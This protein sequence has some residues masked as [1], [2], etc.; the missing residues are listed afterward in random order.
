[1]DRAGAFFLKQA[2]ADGGV[3][4]DFGNG[5]RAH[6]AIPKMRPDLISPG[7]GKKPLLES[8]RRPAQE[9]CLG[10]TA[11]VRPDWHDRKRADFDK[12]EKVPLPASIEIAH[13]KH[14][15]AA[16]DL[17]KAGEMNGFDAG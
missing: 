17:M 14:P 16:V 10:T 2:G 13:E 11:E 15:L 9:S 4:V 3:A 7:E 5:K 6:R 1:M 12:I 8:R